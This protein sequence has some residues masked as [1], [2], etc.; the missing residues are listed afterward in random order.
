MQNF[1]PCQK[2][3]KHCSDTIDRVENQVQV[4]AADGSLSE[5]RSFGGRP[6]AEAD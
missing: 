2:L 4:I 6:E 1:W 3:V 5:L